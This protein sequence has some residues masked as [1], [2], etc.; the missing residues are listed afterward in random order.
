MSAPAPKK[1][2]KRP[3]V[4][5]SSRPTLPFLHELLSLNDL[6]TRKARAREHCSTL[7]EI[8]TYQGMP[9]RV[10][11]YLPKYK[12]YRANEG[13][14]C[15]RISCVFG[16]FDESWGAYRERHPHLSA[17]TVKNGIEILSAQPNATGHTYSTK[18]R[19]TIKE[20]KEACK[21]NGIKPTGDKTALLSA[22][23]KI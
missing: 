17:N 16:G 22:L 9:S 20:L 21:A 4:A 14:A 6:T 13:T 7:A 23:M 2:M 8:A 12:Q 10:F 19:I 3:T 15:S 5:V 11:Q 1:L 18:C